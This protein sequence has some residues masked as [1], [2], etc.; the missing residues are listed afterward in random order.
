MIDTT[1][2]CTEQ[3]MVVDG[4]ITTA[5]EADQEAEILPGEMRIWTTNGVHRHHTHKEELIQGQDHRDT[6][7]DQDLNRPSAKTDHQES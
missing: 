7:Q 3:T 4:E 5:R 6:D 2:R 1:S